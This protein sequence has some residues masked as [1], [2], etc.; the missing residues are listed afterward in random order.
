MDEQ[1]DSQRSRKRVVCSVRFSVP[2]AP[3]AMTLKILWGCVVC[4]AV[5]CAH[6]TPAPGRYLRQEGSSSFSFRAP[7]TCAGRVAEI[8]M[9]VAMV[10]A[11]IH[12]TLLQEITAA[13]VSSHAINVGEPVKVEDR[14]ARDW[15]AGRCRLRCV[16]RSDEMRG[17][18]GA[19]CAVC[20][21]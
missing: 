21:S 9:M 4:V 7:D 15:I 3:T 16:V 12:S 2:Y 13:N 19:V 17:G 10:K 11:L 1:E 6:A 8:V 18:D 5:A 14:M 20:L